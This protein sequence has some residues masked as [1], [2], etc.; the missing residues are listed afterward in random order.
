MDANAKLGKQVIPNDPNDQSKNGKRLQHI[1]EENDLIIVNA[2]SVC[3]GAITRYRKTKN[4]E[5]RS[6]LDYF[7][8]CQKF[9]NHVKRLE[10]DEKREYCLTKYATKLG[11][12]SHKESDHN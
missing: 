6:I 3:T 9:F 5:E 2:S 8:V 7:I 10:I 4:S 12:E 11:K 1:V